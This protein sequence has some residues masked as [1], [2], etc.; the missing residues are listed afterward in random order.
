MVPFIP[1]E[2]RERLTDK[3][4]ASEKES[5]CKA[6]FPLLTMGVGVEA[7]GRDHHSMSPPNQQYLSRC[8]RYEQ[9]PHPT[10]SIVAMLARL[11]NHQ[12]Q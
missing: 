8:P 6:V 4:N 5:E 12:N 10:L 2:I 9:R 3:L 1:V 11:Q 7:P